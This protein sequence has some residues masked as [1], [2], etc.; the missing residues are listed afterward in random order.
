[1][2]PA[3]KIAA[4]C[5]G[6]DPCQTHDSG[7][8]YCMSNAWRLLA[9]VRNQLVLRGPHLVNDSLQVSLLPVCARLDLIM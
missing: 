1:M 4:L 7:R 8:T 6:G 5:F 2:I 3:S 9:A